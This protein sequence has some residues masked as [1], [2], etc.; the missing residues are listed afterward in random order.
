MIVLDII[1]LSQAV[2]VGS[3]NRINPFFGGAFVLLDEFVVLGFFK[4]E[5]DRGWIFELLFGEF[6][7]G[8]DEMNGLLV[9]VIFSFDLVALT[10]LNILAAPK[11]EHL[12]K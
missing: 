11:Q 4:F 12:N 2:L 6:A 1:D 7:E 5:D 8:G 10:C 3:K 9:V